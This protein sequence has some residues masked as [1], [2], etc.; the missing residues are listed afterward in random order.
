VFTL[1][2]WALALERALKSTAQALLVVWGSAEVN[3]LTVNWTTAVG[4]ALTAGVLSV[5]T[6][7][8]SLPFG[9]TNSPSLVAPPQVGAHE[10]VEG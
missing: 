8:V 6:S 4:V 3:V 5:L 9:P 1:V 2:F 10:K 7:I